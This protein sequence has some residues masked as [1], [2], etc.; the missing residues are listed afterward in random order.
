[1]TTVRPIIE[2]IEKFDGEGEYGLGYRFIMNDISQNIT[3][4][5][6]N[7]QQCFE[8]F[9]V[10]TESKMNDFIGSSFIS[11]EIGEPSCDN[12]TGNGDSVMKTIETYIHTSKGKITIQFYN[13]HNGYYKHDVLIHSK[14]I[15][16]IIG[17]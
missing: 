10:H 4:K 3:C 7:D 8:C 13:E 6:Q 16:K 5:M 1:M 15:N 12:N 11:I 9:G 14:T 2:R 17:I